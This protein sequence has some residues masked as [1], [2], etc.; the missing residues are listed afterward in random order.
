MISFKSHLN[1]TQT[2]IY[3]RMFKK[4]YQLM[5]MYQIS[6]PNIDSNW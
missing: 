4:W 2:H 1:K 5:L 6:M 3:V